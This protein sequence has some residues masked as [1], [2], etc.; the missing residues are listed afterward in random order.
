MINILVQIGFACLA[1]VLAGILY[2]IGMKD[3]N[4]GFI[5]GAVFMGCSW[6]YDNKKKDKSL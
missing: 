5:A 6:L 1:I 4:T 2:H 3:L